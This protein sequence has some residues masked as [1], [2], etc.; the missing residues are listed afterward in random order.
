LKILFCNYEYPPLGGGGGVVMAALA[1]ELARRHEITVLTSRAFNLPF[2]SDDHGVH[3]VRTPVFFR[4]Q[5][6]VANMPS[7]LAFVPMAILRGLTLKRG[8]FDVVN[9]HFVVP[10]GPAGQVLAKLSG[11]P[12]VLSLHGGDLYD[13]SKRISPH[14][15]AWLRGPIRKMLSNADALVGQSRNTVQ[16]VRDIYGVD[17]R[18]ELIPLGIERPPAIVRPARSEFGLPERAFVMTTVG[19]IVPRKATVQLVRALQHASL[20]A[21]HLVIVGEGPDAAAVC[22]VA[23]EAGVQ[24]RV[25]LL[26]PLADRDKYR[27]LSTSDVFVS[28]SQHEG[29]GLVFLEAMA[30]GLPIVCY[31][32]GG[33]TDYLSTQ[34]TG[35][36][37]H[38]NDLDAFTRALVDLSHSEAARTAIGACNRKRAE[39]YFIDTCAQRYESIF[40]EVQE[41]R[42]GR[43]TDQR[44]TAT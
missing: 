36:V 3:V 21:A 16:H 28:T 43:S 38:L 44:R 9:T 10:S 42:Y 34:E 25:H 32:N 17:R 31:D 37:I 35:Y 18:V 15:H 4:R 30:M 39:Q 29:F 24:N 27:V 6:A 19:R 40:A 26:G 5:M 23:A 20:A 8:R 11:A 14:R 2:V 41:R 22:R 33:Q 12:H 1:R 13:P 7:L